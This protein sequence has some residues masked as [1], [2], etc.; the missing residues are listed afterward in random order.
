MEPIASDAAHRRWRSA[1]VGF[2]CQEKNAQ[3]NDNHAPR[4]PC[5]G[6]LIPL[7]YALYKDWRARAAPHP[8][9]PALR[10]LARTHVCAGLPGSQTDE[11]GRGRDPWRA[12]LSQQAEEASLRSIDGAGAARGC[13]V[14][15]AMASDERIEEVFVETSDDDFQYEEVEIE[16]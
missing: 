16:R 14:V 15:G 11:R 3:L 13:T 6:S 10:R 12:Y 9:L 4:S 5:V 2:A 7:P 1:R 8:S